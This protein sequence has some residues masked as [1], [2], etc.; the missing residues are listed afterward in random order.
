M[1]SWAE[2]A[3]WSLFYTGLAIGMLSLESY[4]AERRAPGQDRFGTA[5]IFHEAWLAAA[6]MVTAGLNLVFDT[7]PR[8]VLLML[9]AAWLLMY[10]VK[11]LLRPPT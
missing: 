5:T 1:T 4:A 11:R 2:W 8:D 6:V 7:G 9:G 10:L 3:G